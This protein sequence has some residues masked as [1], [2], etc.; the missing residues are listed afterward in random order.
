MKIVMTIVAKSVLYLYEKVEQ[1][2]YYFPL[3]SSCRFASGDRVPTFGWL[4]VCST[5]YK[6]FEKQL[7]GC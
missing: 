5:P 4:T 2:K 6:V 1:R 3:S 7:S